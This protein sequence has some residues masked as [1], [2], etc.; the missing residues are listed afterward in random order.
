MRSVV[1]TAISLA[2]TLSAG[3]FASAGT[4]PGPH[5]TFAGRE[6]GGTIAFTV[7][8][9]FEPVSASDWQ[10][11]TWPEMEAIHAEVVVQSIGTGEGDYTVY[12]TSAMPISVAWF[13][14]LYS[15]PID[16]SSPPSQGVML[17]ATGWL[18]RV[19]SEPTPRP[20]YLRIVGEMSAE[21]V[22]TR[23][24]QR[25]ELSSAVAL[26]AADGDVCNAVFGGDVSRLVS[27]HCGYAISHP[28]VLF[29]DITAGV[30]DVDGR[31]LASGSFELELESEFYRF[32][33]IVPPPVDAAQCVEGYTYLPSDCV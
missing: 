30:V 32:P 13:G 26:R 10:M 27:F 19:E 31:E 6:D 12:V 1:T 2:F 4:V 33:T 15:G 16:A 21:L 29:L 8:R 28:G 17:G 20:E 22:F 3:C 11:I 25:P 24:V 7:R 23:P 14:V 18:W 5:V 9:A